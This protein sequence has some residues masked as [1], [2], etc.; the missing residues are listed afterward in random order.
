MI[1]CYMQN[2]KES[3]GLD[4]CVYLTKCGVKKR[5]TTFPNPWTFLSHILCVRGNFYI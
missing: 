4:F 3:I 2:M 5:S 1:L